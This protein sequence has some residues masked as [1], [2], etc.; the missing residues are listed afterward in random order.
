MVEKKQKSFWYFS[1]QEKIDLF[2]SW[3][4][5]S[6]AFAVVINPIFLNLTNMIVSFPIALV[7]VGTGFVFHELAHRQTARHFGFHSEFRAWY[8]GLVIALGLAIVSFGQFIFA[9]PGA[10]YFFAH[11]VTRKQ[12]GLISIAGPAINIIIGLSLLI[13][14]AIIVENL[15]VTILSYAALINFWF[16]LFNLLP[17][18]PLDGAKVLHW[19]PVVWLGAIALSG[20]LAFMPGLF[21]ASIGLAI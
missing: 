16:A 4:T 11:N 19:K 5:L 13:L 18:Y 17:V 7:A 10:T 15:V 9:A 1:K 6:I 2:I 12:N 3:I 8:P 14:S 21:L 20:I